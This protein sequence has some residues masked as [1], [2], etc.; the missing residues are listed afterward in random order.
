MTNPFEQR[1]DHPPHAAALRRPAAAG[2]RRASSAAAA[3]RLGARAA[4]H[5]VPDSLPDPKR[6][7][8]TRRRRAAVRPHRRRDDGE[9]LLRQPARRAART[10]GSRRR[11]GLQLQRAR[12]SR[13]T[14]TRAATGRCAR[15][16]PDHRAGAARHADLERD[17][18]AD[19]RRQDGR[20]R[21]A[22]SATT[23]RWATGP[24]TCCRSPTRSRA[25]SR[26]PTAGS[27]RRRARPT[28]TAAS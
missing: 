25:P 3:R 26:S 17:P 24:R 20:L 13:S 11:T 4:A 16:R 22:R 14:A 18:R 21:R 10:P 15:S 9:P 2:A 27:A 28:P 7:A 8:G 6:P 5:A 19:R 12:A 23:S 1:P